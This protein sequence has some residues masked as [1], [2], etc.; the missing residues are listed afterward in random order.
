MLI[1]CGQDRL[2][3]VLA[4]FMTLHYSVAYV[5]HIQT[6]E[7]Q[8]GKNSRIPGTN[9]DDI[10]PQ[11][12]RPPSFQGPQ[13]R[14]R[15]SML[16]RSQ[17]LDQKQ[18]DIV[19][20]KGRVFNSPLFLMRIVTGQAD[21]RLSAVTPQKMSKKATERNR[22]RRAMYEALASVGVSNIASI[23]GIVFAKPA[24]IKATTSDIASGL[25][26]FFEKAGL[27]R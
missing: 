14:Q 6:K 11:G 5:I 16:P 10:R 1:K 2:F 12:A 20:E 23:H 9:E 7:A 24:M 3:P 26:A 22:I 27:L 4:D 17:R 19:M 8:A 13:A 18:F 21:T 15:I 25:K